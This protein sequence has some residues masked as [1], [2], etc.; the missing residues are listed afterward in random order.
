MLVR[1]G[2]SFTSIIPEISKRSAVAKRGQNFVGQLCSLLAE[3][4]KTEKGA[5]PN[6]KQKQIHMKLVW[7]L[8]WILVKLGN[9]F[10]R[11]LSKF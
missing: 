8:K 5:T 11:V 7:V 2:F 4:P 3:N 6:G 10:T 1:K 9:N